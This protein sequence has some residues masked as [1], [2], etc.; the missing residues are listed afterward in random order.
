V[1]ANQQGSP[2]RGDSEL[3]SPYPLPP[4]PGNAVKDS[5]S[6]KTGVY[7][8]IGEDEKSQ[9]PHTHPLTTNQLERNL[10]YEFTEEIAQE[11]FVT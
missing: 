2:G 7:G 9:I 1:S 10:A 3:S 4:L 6:L 5:E 11:Q 8:N